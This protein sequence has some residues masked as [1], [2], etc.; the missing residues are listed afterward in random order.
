VNENLTNYRRGAVRTALASRVQT[1][2]DADRLW[3]VDTYMKRNTSTNEVD[4]FIRTP[5]TVKTNSNDFIG[6]PDLDSHGVYDYFGNVSPEHEHA[7]REARLTNA[8]SVKASEQLNE[9]YPQ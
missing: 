9:D 2:G 3:S 7:G 5:E 6:G 4:K 8:F 1:S